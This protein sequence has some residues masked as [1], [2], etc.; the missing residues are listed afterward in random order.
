MWLFLFGRFLIGQTC[1]GYRDTAHLYYPLFEWIQN[2]WSQGEI[3]LWNPLDDFGQ[4]LVADGV[5]SVFYP[6]KAIFFMTLLPYAV[7][8]AFYVSIHAIITA[9]GTYFLARSLRFS[10]AVSALSASGFALSGA[11]LFQTSN[12]VYLVGAAWLPWALASGWAALR[13]GKPRALVGCAVFIAFMIL[14]GDPQSAYHALLILGAT[15][16]FAMRRPRSITNTPTRFASVTRLGS[17]VLVTATLS[18]VQWLPSWQWHQRS[19]RA[20]E[21]HREHIY[22]FSQPPWSVAELIWPNVSGKE[23]PTFRRWTSAIPAAD[24]VWTPSLYFGLAVALLALFGARLWRGS[25]LIVG[26]TWLTILF[27]LGSC[28]W[29]GVGWIAREIGSLF[30]W[31]YFDDFSSPV[32][33]IYWWMVTLLPGFV[34]FRYPAKLFVVATLGASLLAGHQLSR[35]NRERSKSVRVWAA[36]AL[37]ASVLMLGATFFHEVRGFA[38]GIRADSTFGPFDLAGSFKDLRIAFAHASIVSGLLWLILRPHRNASISKSSTVRRIVALTVADLVVANAWLIVGVPAESF[39]TQIA[40]SVATELSTEKSFSRTRRFY[41]DVYQPAS[42]RFTKSAKR[43]EE[44]I[45]FERASLFPKFHLSH[46]V[47]LIGS[48][49]ALEPLDLAWFNEFVGA[50]YDPVFA[51]E[52]RIMFFN[53]PLEKVSGTLEAIEKEAITT[54]PENSRHL[55]QHSQNLLVESLPVSPRLSFLAD[56]TPP[57]FSRATRFRADQQHDFI[58][59][60]RRDLAQVAQ[61]DARFRSSFNRPVSGRSAEPENF[62]TARIVGESASQVH[63]HVRCQAAG[64]LVLKDYWDAG[65]SADIHDRQ[66]GTH[67]ITQPERFCGIF[68]A[69]NLPHSGEFDVH[70]VYRPRSFFWGA[71]ISIATIVFIFIAN[72]IRWFHL[73]RQLPAR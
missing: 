68:R 51:I 8:F 29:Y 15:A 32:F 71:T 20:T 47:D 38:L 24:R 27:G 45:R 73:R 46:N 36:V 10:P 16:I 30:G 31:K 28:G 56:W 34:S 57:N 40:E 1:F 37:V 50:A 44:V 70:F 3:P 62:P 11:V 49:H 72:L 43:L 60:I 33:G 9:W 55:F 35:L 65:W 6:L 64:W 26:L 69:V 42:W 53:P 7:R 23:F 22:Q 52:N 19:L 5:S 61:A 63:I 4:P 18:A 39:T 41:L 48:F 21:A 17:I 12:V 58:F 14:G 59:A 67:L 25:K 13:T 2:Q 54:L 66:T